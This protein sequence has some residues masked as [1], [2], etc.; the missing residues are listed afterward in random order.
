[1]L[2]RKKYKLDIGLVSGSMVRR[3]EPDEVLLRT[4]SIVPIGVLLVDCPQGP[5]RQT[6][7]FLF[8]GGAK[9][10]PSCSLGALSAAAW[11]FGRRLVCLR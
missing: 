4:A 2:F 6:G 9:S 8:V 10:V 11:Q 7:T 5:A 3:R 1:M